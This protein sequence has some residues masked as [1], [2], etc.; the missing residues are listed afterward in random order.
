VRAVVPPKLHFQDCTCSPSTSLN[1]RP[2]TVDRCKSPQLDRQNR[3]LSLQPWP[4][5]LCRHLLDHRARGD[6]PQLA[7]GGAVGRRWRRRGAPPAA[8]C[9]VAAGCVWPARGRRMY[10][11][12]RASSWLPPAGPVHPHHGGSCAVDM[13]GWWRSSGG[14][15][16]VDC[17]L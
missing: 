3:Y 17:R 9:V 11:A 15:V 6:Q 12:R 1:S 16:L 13:H 14:C 2:S 5:S 7:V 10:A 8:A 4:F